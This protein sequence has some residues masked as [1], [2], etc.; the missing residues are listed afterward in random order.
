MLTDNLEITRPEYWNKIYTGKNNDAPVDASNTKRTSTFDRFNI[1]VNHAEGKRILGVGSGHAAIEK[2]I[3]AKFPASLV[4]A[5]DQCAA[6]KAVAHYTPFEIFSAYTIPYPDKYFD[7]LIITQ[8]LEYLEHQDEFML[9]AKRV[10]RKFMCTVPI[11]EMK[12]WS[13]LFIYEQDT[14]IQWLGNYGTIEVVERYFDLLLVKIR[15][16]D[17]A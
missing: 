11:G 9:E 17:D 8:A 1:V 14:F 16:T 13:Q 2:R 3:S 12:K 10:S 5:S 7:L 4:I 15:F 6:A